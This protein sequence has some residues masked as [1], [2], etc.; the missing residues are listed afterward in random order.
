VNVL[1][2]HCP[3]LHLRHAARVALKHLGRLRV[4]FQLPLEPGRRDDGKT[5]TVWTA[6]GA[7]SISI[8]VTNPPPSSVK[9]LNPTF[10]GTSFSFSFATQVGHTY[11]AQFTQAL[12]PTNWLTFTNLIGSGS[13][14][15]V[16][17]STLTNAQRYYRVGAQ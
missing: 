15:Q 2:F 6:V 4:A 14:V 11:T 16:T 7:N 5:T 12:N 8:S 13:T 17:D 9:I 3:T 1:L 10:N